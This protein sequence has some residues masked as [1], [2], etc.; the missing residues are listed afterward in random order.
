MTA[1]PDYSISLQALVDGELDAAHA[2]EVEAHLSGCAAC[3]RAR[4]DA[5][6][7]RTALRSV[8]VR[9]EAPDRLRSRLDAA[10]RAASE[11]VAM[12]P[13]TK[14]RR[15]RL[16]W[17][18]GGAAATMAAC[19]ALA[20]VAVPTVQ[21]AELERQIVASHVRSQLAGHLIDVAASD[22]HVVKPWFGG[23]VDFSPPVIDLADKGFPMVG[24]RLDYVDR[25]TVAAVVYRRG[26]HVI[27][28]F[29]WPDG[30]A[31][32]P[33]EANPGDGYRMLHWARGGMTYWAVSDVNEADLRAFCRLL[34]SRA[35]A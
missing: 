27:N 13:R 12:R 10:A 35:A 5:L 7:L 8:G 18:F 3:A 6:A 11:P 34:Q 4:D 32:A 1:C 15:D 22:K 20:I 23:K 26:L 29:V 33:E 31:H 14:Q 19:A 16:F 24:G 28:L 21:T 2:V 9:A 30:W 17:G 25:R